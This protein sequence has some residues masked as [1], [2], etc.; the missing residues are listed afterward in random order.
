M[1]CA[2]KI[3]S[4]YKT[5]PTIHCANKINKGRINKCGAKHDNYEQKKHY[6]HDKAVVNATLIAKLEN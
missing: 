4:V 6:Y 5:N 3:T 1:K 2:M